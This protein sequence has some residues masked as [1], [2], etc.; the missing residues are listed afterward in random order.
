VPGSTALRIPRGV[1]GQTRRPRC[2]GCVAAPVERRRSVLASRSPRRYE[3]QAERSAASRSDTPQGRTRRSNVAETQDARRQARPSL[4]AG[5]TAQDANHVSERRARGASGA[6]CNVETRSLARATGVGPRA[7]GLPGSDRHWREG[8]EE[9]WI[10]AVSASSNGTERASP[11][12]VLRVLRAPSRGGGQS[13]NRG[14]RQQRGSHPSNHRETTNGLPTNQ[15][16]TAVSNM[17]GRGSHEPR[18][19][20]QGN[21]ATG[22]N[23]RRR[24]KA[25]TAERANRQRNG[26]TR[27]G[28]SRQRPPGPHPY[29]VTVHPGV[30]FASFAAP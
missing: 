1:P 6:A 4:Y 30:V 2:H 19:A 28:P 26:R 17:H 14:W 20:R 13:P 25:S 8:R 9:T 18:A 22:R 24:S 5:I 29:L 3:R 15:R 7:P 16:A 12:R 21:R 11:T 10:T 27:P 23:P